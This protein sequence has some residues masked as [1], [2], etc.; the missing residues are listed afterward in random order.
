MARVKNVTGKLECL[1]P[2]AV[3]SAP[4]FMG[5]G[6]GLRLPDV[7]GAYVDLSCPGTA[8]CEDTDPSVTGLGRQHPNLT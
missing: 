4:S 7:R 2:F 1:E 8:V 6:G 5:E 3:P